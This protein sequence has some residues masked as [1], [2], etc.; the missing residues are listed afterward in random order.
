MLAGSLCSVL[1]GLLFLGLGFGVESFSIHL[2][3]TMSWLF[4]MNVMLG[5]FNL[6]PG[7]PLDG[8]R[9]FSALAWTVFG[10]YTRATRVAI[11][12]GQVTALAF[13]AIGVG[14]FLVE[15]NLVQGRWMGLIGWF[16]WQA[17]SGSSAGARDYKA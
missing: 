5:T 10:N 15:R 17:P 12:G 3:V 6:I 7:F 14:F 4:L 2:A 9:V 8:G 13:A 1:L 11:L 16:L